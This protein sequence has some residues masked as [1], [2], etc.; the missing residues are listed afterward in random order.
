MSEEVAVETDG[1]TCIGRWERDPK[2]RG[3]PQKLDGRET[4]AAL[5]PSRGGP[6]PHLRSGTPAGRFCWR[7]SQ[8]ELA[9]EPFG[10]FEYYI[11]V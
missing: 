7:K 11:G 10:L 9:S 4:G 5:R 1:E 3:L 2:E 8:A 6:C